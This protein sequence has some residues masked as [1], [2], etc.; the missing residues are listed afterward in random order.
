MKKVRNILLAGIVLF[1]LYYGGQTFLKNFQKPDLVFIPYLHLFTADKP[2]ALDKVIQKNIDFFHKTDN[3]NY[4]FEQSLRKIQLKKIWVDKY[5]VTQKEFSQFTQWHSLQSHPT[6]KNFPAGWKPYSSTVNHA[7]F[8]RLEFPANGV[9]FYDA[10]AYCKSAGGNI[11]TTTQWEAIASGKKNFLYP[12][13]NE[14]NYSS[15]VHLD[16]RLNL[17]TQK[18][19]SITAATPTGIHNMGSS[20]SEWTRGAFPAQLPIIKGGNAYNKPYDIYALN[21]FYRK[22]PSEYRS[23]YLGFRCIFHRKV[24]KTPWNTPLKVRPIKKNKYQIGVKQTHLVRLINFIDK[25]DVPKITQI[26]ERLPQTQENGFY[27]SKYEVTVAEYAKFLADPFT[28]IGIYANKNEPQGISYSPFDWEQQK[29]HPHRP[30]RNISWWSAYAYSN[31]IGGALPTEEEWI[32]ASSNNMKHRYP[33]GNKYQNFSLVRGKKQNY[34]NGVGS[35]EKDLTK[36]GV[37]DMAG[38]V[39]EWTRTVTV[40]QAGFK[41]KVKGGNF[42]IPGEKF[43]HS[44]SE[45][46]AFPHYT[47]ESIGFRVVFYSQ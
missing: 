30:V 22:A 34:P 6:R 9:S 20:V 31:W 8:G 32:L 10:L 25:E 19:H 11:P 24:K 33:W 17:A 43:A 47:S 41:V 42:L 26:I 45:I 37:Y 18:S 3:S 16:T 12:W 36:S 23:P 39:S 44:F 4:I 5:E 7:I 35:M 15:W 40:E 38:N 21:I 1:S 14:M 46:T 13:G 2:T 27:I 29:Q 28:F